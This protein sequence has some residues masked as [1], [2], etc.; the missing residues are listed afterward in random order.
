MTPTLLMCYGM[1]INQPDEV[2]ISV[3]RAYVVEERC[4]IDWTTGSNGMKMVER[5]DKIW[6]GKSPFEVVHTCPH[7]RA[8]SDTINRGGILHK[9]EK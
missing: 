8:R 3:D 6:T 9:A 7:R 4:I 5:N 1:K 2:I